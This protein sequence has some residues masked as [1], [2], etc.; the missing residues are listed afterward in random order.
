[1]FIKFDNYSSKSAIYRYH[2]AP[3]L[4]LPSTGTRGSWAVFAG[5]MASAWSASL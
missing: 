4:T 1:M 3:I 2:S 5:H